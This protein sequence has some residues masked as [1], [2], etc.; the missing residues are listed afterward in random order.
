M[1]YK[2]KYILMLDGFPEVHPS[3]KVKLTS[4]IA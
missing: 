1:K 2:M 4:C 3:V